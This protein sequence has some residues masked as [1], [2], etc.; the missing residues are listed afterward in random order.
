MTAV[1][2][3]TPMVARTAT[4]FTFESYLAIGDT[5]IDLSTYSAVFTAR[6]QFGSSIV[7]VTLS[8]PTIELGADGTVAFTIP[9]EVMAT[10]AP[11]RGVYDLVI[12]NYSGQDEYVLSGDFIV[13]PAV[14]LDV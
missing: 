9:N 1:N 12:R 10:I 4:T 14:T 8:S 2:T 13:G 5:R 11:N 3:T 6:P 7:W